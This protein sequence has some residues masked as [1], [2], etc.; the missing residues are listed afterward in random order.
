MDKEESGRP[1]S[2]GSQRVGPDKQL[3]ML[4]VTYDVQCLFVC[5]LAISISSMMCPILY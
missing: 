5:L 3:S 1:V 2:I 4:A